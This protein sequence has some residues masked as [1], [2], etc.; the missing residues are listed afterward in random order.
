MISQNL[1]CLKGIHLFNEP[2]DKH[3][4]LSAVEKTKY[5]NLIKTGISRTL[6][7][8][9]LYA[10]Y[11]GFISNLVKDLLSKIS[12]VNDW[13]YMSQFI[14]L[15]CEAA[16]D[17]V[18]D[19]LENSIDNHTG[20]LDLFTAEKANI[21]MGRHYYTHILWCIEKLLPCN[22][23]VVRVCMILLKLS[24]KIDKCSTG[25]IPRDVLSKVFCTWYNV[26][27]L[28]I[29]DKIG[30]AKYGIEKYPYFW[31]ILFDEIKRW[32]LIFYNTGFMYRENDKIIPYTQKDIFNFNISYTEILLSNIGNNLERLIKILDL[33]PECTDKLFD[34]IK[35]KMS[36][37]IA[38]LC[39][40]DKEQ[41]KTAL[42][43]IIHSHRHFANSE[44][45]AS[46]ERISRIEE[47]CL[48][49]TF[50]DQAYDF[51]Y[52]TESG[53]IPI[54]NPAVFDS[55]GDYYDRN[56]DAVKET[57]ASEMIRL[58]ELNIDLGH[59]L[60]L[61]NIES[62]SVIGEAI[63]KYYCNSK[64]DERILDTIIDSTDNPRIAVE[65]VRS[66]TT[67]ELS[68][69]YEAIEHLKNDHYADKFYVAF[70]RAL[71]F[72]KKSQSLIFDLPSEAAMDYW[73]NFSRF[74][75]QS[76]DLLI[77]AIEN[78]V[79]YSN[80]NTLYDVMYKQADMLNTEEILTIISDSTKK[81]ITENYQ[82]GT[83]KSYFIEQLLT[84]V[85]QR[86]GDDFENYP[87][88]LEIE[89]CLYSVIGWNNMK[90][91]KY[92]FKHNANLY[93]DI[94][95]LTYKK[96][97]GSFDEKL[98]S[99]R[100]MQFYKLESDIKFYPGEENGSINKEVLN[101][102]ISTFSDRLT[103]Q[104]QYSLFNR[105][106]GE[107]FACSPTGV[108]GIFPHEIIREKIEEIGNKELIDSF[109]TAII[110]SRGVYTVTDGKEEFK[111][112]QKYGEQSRELLLSY[113]KTSKIFK[114]VSKYYLRES[115]RDR[116][117][118][119][120]EIY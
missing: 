21:F 69:V 66:C 4:Y 28:S 33:L 26:S 114:L 118:A 55:T 25:N 81:I 45:A 60:G 86:I 48:E 76:K 8:L 34:S 91:C 12:S 88:L 36:T 5:S 61:R 71:P 97:D 59:F 80:W 22:D 57:I 106:I 18:V 10:D 11:Q 109:A 29:E 14:E 113:P 15:F 99:D 104:W 23:Y 64:Y 83:N 108:D 95:S 30:L 51:L 6:I 35:C 1:L 116:R 82:I 117:F 43:K 53:D 107:L 63:A 75:F 77:E 39:D 24:S 74:R 119:E 9:A 98:D 111:L 47:L 13:A 46:S 112:A 20:L 50:D 44:W 73:R 93:A 115:E 101:E 42:R 84:N 67:S 78:L 52:L 62:Y 49:I 96:D 31:D 37:I 3:L 89:M 79:M 102:W 40:S 65:Y 100:L 38:G 19:C 16:P 17:A 92:L 41:I 70:L 2:F 32:T 56:E 54:F 85:Y 110:N 68:E 87:I 105:K 27:A 120:N 90:C 103:Y 7:L 72:D 94:L 58:K